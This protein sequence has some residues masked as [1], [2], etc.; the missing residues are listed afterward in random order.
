[1]ILRVN[2]AR[3]V[4]SLVVALALADVHGARRAIAAA[5][6]HGRNAQ[7]VGHDLRL[8]RG[9]RRRPPRG[10][11]VRTAT[12][13]RQVVPSS[14]TSGFAIDSSAPRYWSASRAQGVAGNNRSAHPS[15]S[16]DGRF[17]AFSSSATNLDPLDTNDVDDIF[18]HDR[19]ADGNGVF[20][21]P[22]G[23]PLTSLTRASVSSFAGTVQLRQRSPFDQQHRP[24]RGVRLLRHQ[25]DR[26]RRQD[27]RRAGYFRSRPG[28]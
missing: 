28:A 19:D 18:V 25:L 26:G 17:I 4:A 3:Q 22:G 16:A 14:F 7:L 11:R 15:I 5:H 10:V 27:P 12:R 21:E 9:Q 1:M 8:P 20:D 24:L 23:M 2:R 6:R 13:S